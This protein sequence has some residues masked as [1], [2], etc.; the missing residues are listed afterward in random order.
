MNQSRRE[1]PS[2]PVEPGRG[3]TPSATGTRG[4]LLQAGRALFVSKGFDGA[5]VRAI[6]ER[7]G[8]NLGA[9]TYH[10]GSKRQLYHAVLEREITPLADQVARASQGPGPA[11]G[12]MA[13]VVGAFFEHFQGHP[14]MPRLMLQEIAA[15]KEPPPVVAA[16]L[17]RVMGT[18]SGIQREGIEDGT[19]RPGHPLLTALS[20]VAQPI[21]MTL[22][23]PFLK[24]IT[25]LDLADPATRAA[26][27]EHASAFVRAG[28]TPE[29][30]AGGPSDAA[31]REELP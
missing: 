17:K 30:T 19:I 22:V 4:A 8:A 26:A 23:S 11:V 12:R 6:T 18:L 9:V 5:S 31:S 20:V 15:G 13:A 16:T 28:L 3:T 21:Y 10:F 25:G 1:D 27:V 24:A 7:A 29:A 14:D 2:T